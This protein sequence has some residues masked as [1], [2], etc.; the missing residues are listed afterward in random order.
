MYEIGKS[1]LELSLI[2]QPEYLFMYIGN[3]EIK[4][5]GCEELS[6]A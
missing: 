3:N 4:D 5:K 6:K 2:A 1:F